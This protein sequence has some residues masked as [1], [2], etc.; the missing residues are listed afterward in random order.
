MPDQ[1]FGGCVG[2]TTA[3]ALCIMGGCADGS[4]E[5]TFAGGMVGCASIETYA[6]RATLCGPGYR[7]ATAAEWVALR[8]GI[9]PTHNYWTNDPLKYSGSGPSIITNK[10][11]YLI[12]MFW[13]FF[14]PISYFSYK[15]NII[16]I[17]L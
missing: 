15:T 12:F 11:K 17:F 8:N 7:V 13:Q 3:G 14:C 4:I 6:N 5:Q 16:I 10:S 1:F 2:N 9:A